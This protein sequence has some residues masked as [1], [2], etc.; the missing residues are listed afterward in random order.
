MFKIIS[1]ADYQY[2]RE[3]V[4]RQEAE[5]NRLKA[6][7]QRDLIREILKIKPLDFKF[8]PD[9]ERYSDPAYIK[10]L[11]DL[12]DNS[13]LREEFKKVIHNSV[14]QSAMMAPR[15]ETAELLLAGNINCIDVLERLFQDAKDFLLQAK[16]N[17]KEGIAG[18]QIKK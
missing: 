1:K 18:W 6:K 14:K 9:E 11:A 4:D 3:L 5:I 8:N 12:A 7:D 13:I 2:L 17:Q 15:N 10:G 16:E